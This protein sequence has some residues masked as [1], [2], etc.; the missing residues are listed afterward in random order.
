MRVEGCNPALGCTIVL[1]GPLINDE[2]RKVKA[3][4]KRILPIARSIIIER[5]F[6]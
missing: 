4:V 3:S 2:L 5:Y 6:I 1:E